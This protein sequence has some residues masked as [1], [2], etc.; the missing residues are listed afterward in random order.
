MANEEQ[1]KESHRILVKIGIYLFQYLAKMPPDKQQEFV[2]SMTMS[3]DILI[4]FH[5]MA[6]RDMKQFFKAEMDKRG[7]LED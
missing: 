5:D 1:E 4:E 3:D 7:I 2:G 6:T